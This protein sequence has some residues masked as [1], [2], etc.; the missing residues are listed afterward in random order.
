[1]REERHDIGKALILVLGAL[2][3]VPGTFSYYVLVNALR[4]QNLCHIGPI[5]LEP[6][7]LNSPAKFQEQRASLRNLYGTYTTFDDASYYFVKT[8]YD[9]T[10]QVLPD[11]GY[12]SISTLAL[13]LLSPKLRQ[14]RQE[15]WVSTEE[16]SS[17]PSIQW[18][19]SH[20]VVINP[21]EHSSKSNRWCLVN[22]QDT[23]VYHKDTNR[24][25]T[26]KESSS[27]L[28]RICAQPQTSILASGDQAPYFVELPL[29]PP[30]AGVWKKYETESVM[31]QVDDD[32]ST[33]KLY[34]EY[35]RSR[36]PANPYQ[37]QVQCHVRDMELQHL[38]HGSLQ[39]DAEPHL[40]WEHA[41][42]I[43][44][45]VWN[46]FYTP[47]TLVV[48]LAL[49]SVQLRRRSS[50][51]CRQV[52]AEIEWNLVKAVQEIWFHDNWHQ[53]F[54]TSAWV[55]FLGACLEPLVGTM[56][57]LGVTVIL[58]Q[59]VSL[60]GG[61]FLWICFGQSV[62]LAQLEPAMRISWVEISSI[63]LGSDSQHSLK[64]NVVSILVALMPFLQATD[65]P[66]RSAFSSLLMGWTLARPLAMEL[67]GAPQWT[68]PALLL[69]HLW[70]KLTK[71]PEDLKKTDEEAAAFCDGI[72]DGVPVLQP[73]D[74]ESVSTIDANN[75]TAA[76]DSAVKSKVVAFIMTAAA[77]VLFG[78]WTLLTIGCI[79]TMDWTLV[80]GNML[81]IWLCIGTNQFP[82]HPLWSLYHMVA[83]SMLLA[84]NTM[85]LA[86]WCLCH[87]AISTHA[88]NALSPFYVYASMG[89]QMV[90]H[91]A[92]LIHTVHTKH[93][94]TSRHVPGHYFWRNVRMI[95]EEIRLWYHVFL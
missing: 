39:P 32:D 94:E 17:A 31:T 11:Y 3:V 95:G 6:N 18:D 41:E 56:P 93:W 40:G 5:S 50:S 77:Y 12:W 55:Y 62:L 51:S 66:W 37:L 48:L 58:L 1:M 70:W 76:V 14:R 2:I 33:D 74:A 89:L 47:G 46:V 72:S 71:L 54:L 10:P 83:S 25:G 38:A 36:K 7:G 63:A 13:T 68:V 59:L 84:V 92:A 8:P 81:T 22:R 87:V 16:Y 79:F 57:Y 23:K 69:G 21:K 91:L 61:G 9:I 80:V 60:T 73:Y 26:A 86:G 44:F 24:K 27:P 67:L 90:V 15:N 85:T 28:F 45:P 43:T 19:Q 78:L 88:L 35:K 82:R 42:R 30:M 52:P 53:Y 4:E 75:T 64:L 20:E 49:L 65:I 29:Q 34:K